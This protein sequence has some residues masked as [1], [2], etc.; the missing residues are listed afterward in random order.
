MFPAEEGGYARY[1][2]LRHSAANHRSPFPLALFP[3]FGIDAALAGICRTVSVRLLKIHFERRKKVDRPHTPLFRA[4]TLSPLVGK[5]FLREVG[6]PPSS[7]PIAI[8]FWCCRC[9]L[10]LYL[11]TYIYLYMCVCSRSTHSPLFPSHPGTN[12]HL[13]PAPGQPLPLNYTSTTCAS[14]FQPR[15]SARTS[16]PGCLSPHGQN[17]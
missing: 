4:V 11:H 10:L 6:S 1:V 12:L 9:S 2:H 13:N 8:P 7:L 17:G 16:W 15:R 5:V 3:P 14:K